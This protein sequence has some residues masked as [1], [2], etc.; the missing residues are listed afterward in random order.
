[1]ADHRRPK[2]AGTDMT[3]RAKGKRPAF[4]DDV[5]I[6][7]LT[8]MVLALAG[9]VSVLRERAD[10]LEHLLEQAGIVGAGAVDEFVPDDQMEAEREQ[11]RAAFLDRVLW[12]V[13]AGQEETSAGETD[14]AYAAIVASLN[15][16]S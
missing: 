4:A 11:R 5:T 7:R 2:T 12:I 10:T 9:E 6:D 1:M 8:S 13:R 16:D 3:P 14:A 15:D